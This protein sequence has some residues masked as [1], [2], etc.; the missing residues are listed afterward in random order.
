MKDRKGTSCV[1]HK[2][3]EVTILLAYIVYKQLLPSFVLEVA[4]S[5]KLPLL[6]PIYG[7]CQLPKERI[8]G[9]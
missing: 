6:L 1:L 9:K 5:S 4:N 3:C 8:C 2:I 7:S